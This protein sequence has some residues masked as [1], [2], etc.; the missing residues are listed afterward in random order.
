VSTL[1]TPSTTRRSA[2]S[3]RGRVGLAAAAALVALPLA[4]GCD[5]GFN[6][7]S[8]T[9]TPDAAAGTID[10]IK[11]NNVWLIVDP[12]TGNAE[13]IGA[14]SNTGGGDVQLTGVQADGMSA[15]VHK[16][17]SS[18]SYP[19]VVVTGNSVTIPNGASVSFGQPGSAVLE[20]AGG[21]F[22]P[23]NL[24]KITFM[25]GTG[26]TLTLTAQV[27]S[28]SGV[29]ATYDPNAAVQPSPSPSPS[30]RSSASASPSG[31]AKPSGSASASASA[32]AS[33]S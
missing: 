8:Q 14:V 24:A 4:A 1:R 13:V 27:E 20:L 10:G 12:A 21:A 5:A 31:S 23:G 29:F 11:V 32:S 30:V 17:T 25:F 3:R 19:G 22:K 28:N 9:V 2:L 26:G 33:K 6:A 15:S 7:A 16:P 18:A